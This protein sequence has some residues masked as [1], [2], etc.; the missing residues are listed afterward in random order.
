MNNPY[1]QRNGVPIDSTKQN[2][3]TSAV[4]KLIER[5]Q[6]SREHSTQILDYYKNKTD[7]RQD[8]MIFAKWRYGTW[9]K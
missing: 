1:A 9:K 6:Q 7:H 2:Q 8:G 3:A 4:D 5:D